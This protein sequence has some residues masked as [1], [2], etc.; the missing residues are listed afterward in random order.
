MIHKI[1][2]EIVKSIRVTTVMITGI[3]ITIIRAVLL[4]SIRNK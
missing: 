2:I 1:R 3:R 4:L